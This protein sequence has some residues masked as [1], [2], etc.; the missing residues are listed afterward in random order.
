MLRTC[1]LQR[2][3]VRKL[4]KSFILVVVLALFSVVPVYAAT[5][6][7]AIVNQI[8]TTSYQNYVNSFPVHKGDNRGF[9]VG[10]TNN[11]V[12]H[13]PQHDQAADLAYLD[14]RRSG[15][16]T[17]YDPFTYNADNGVA[18]SGRNVVAVKQGTTRPDDIYVLGAHYDSK[19]NPGADDNIS[20]VA[21]LLEI[22]RV[23][24]QYTFDCTIVLAIF[25]GEEVTV[26]T[27]GTDIHRLGSVHYVSEH[28]T[29][30]ILG[31][32]SVD[33]I[34]WQSPTDL[35]NMADVEG[36]IVCAPIRN[37][38]K[39]AIQTYGGGLVPDLRTYSNLGPNQG[40]FSDHVAFADAGFQACQFIEDNWWN[41]P[42]Y[43]KAGD[44]V[45]NTDYF[46]WVY[47]TK[48]LKSVTGYL[49]THALTNPGAGASTVPEPGSMVALLAGLAGFSM[50]LKRRTK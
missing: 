48:M 42:N 16:T 26:T 50:F 33:M 2:R 23:L 1:E 14:F 12:Q 18:W 41:N 15:W 49:V 7:Q 32:I 20:G 10:I 44:Y 36:R 38:L 21:G 5:S 30:N 37:D 47:G 22:A 17:M 11:V 40:D 29:D 4:K 31:M 19:N 8:N 28:K 13:G 34:G 35:H 25:D 9:N 46:D 43:H 27:G 3:K 6:V 39:A 45:E 24:S